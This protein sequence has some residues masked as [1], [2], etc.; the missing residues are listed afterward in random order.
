MLKRW[1]A[2][3]VVAACAAGPVPVAHAQVPVPVLNARV[4]DLTG[5]L[6]AEQRNALEQRL[7]AFEA[8][9]GSQIAVLILPTTRP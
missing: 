5:T 2:A 1:L 3:L 6:S 8:K 4:T 9:K 7:A